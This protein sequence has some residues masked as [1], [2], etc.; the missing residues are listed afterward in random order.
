MVRNDGAETR[1][2][3]L[4]E[5][6]RYIIRYE[7]EKIPQKRLLAM[8]SIQTGLSRDRIE[9]MIETLLDSGSIAQDGDF[10]VKGAEF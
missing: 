6:K 4:V 1:R 9:S 8:F 5:L 2:L 10:L 3:R 7:P